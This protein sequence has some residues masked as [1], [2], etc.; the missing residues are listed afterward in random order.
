MFIEFTKAVTLLL[1][2]CLVQGFIARRWPDK[3]LIGQALSGLLFGGICIIGMI[4]PIEVTPGVIFDARSV[5]LSMSG[6]FGGPIVGGIA[7]VMAGGYRAWLG[8]G[9]AP[10]GVSVVISCV[11]L[12]LAYRYCYQRGWLQIGVPAFSVWAVGPFS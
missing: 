12:G 4:N 5:V 8:G 11:L 9:G 2:L 1:A 3:E 10:V 6:L 7:A